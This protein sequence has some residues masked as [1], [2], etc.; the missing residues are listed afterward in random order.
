MAHW[1]RRDFFRGSFAAALAVACPGFL[2]PGGGVIAGPDAPPWPRTWS[3]VN[4]NPPEVFELA[5][6]I[7][8]GE[9]DGPSLPSEDAG[10]PEYDLIVVGGG[11]SG[12]A[13]ALRFR[14]EVRPGS[15]VLIL[16][17]HAE[18][19]GNAR[20]EAFDIGGRTLFATQAG[21]YVEEPWQ[22]ELRDF[23]RRLRVDLDRIRVP[24]DDDRALFDPVSHGCKPVWVPR[25]W[26]EGWAHA[27]V[28]AEDR[29]ALLAFVRTLTEAA[30]AFGDDDWVR[31]DGISFREWIE[32]ERGWPGAVTRFADLYCGDL[33]GARAGAVSAHAGIS[34]CSGMTG[35]ADIYAF[36]GGTSGFTRLAVKALLPDSLAGEPESDDFLAAAWNPEAL[37]RAGEPVRIRLRSTAVRVAHEG[38]PD[39]ARH[40]RVT[41]LRD[42]RLIHARGS[43]VILA[44]GGIMT[45]RIVR[46]LPEARRADFAR[47]R[48]GAYLVA[49]VGIRSSA[50]LDGAGL[51]YQGCL[52]DGFAGTIGVA[53]WVTSGAN[54]ARDPDRPNVLTLFCPLADPAVPVEEQGG[55]GRERLLSTPFVE[56][57]RLVLADLERALGPWGFSADRDVV[58]V[59]LNRWG[60]AMI[61]ACPGFAFERGTDGRALP[62]PC[63]RAAAPFGRLAFAHTDVS[64][65]P[66]LEAAVQEGR[67]AAREAGRRFR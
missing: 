51:G 65:L 66:Y 36:P 19:G 24:K 26:Q 32:K 18:P 20:R 58:A 62:G 38:D 6:R 14:D 40:V 16:E 52:F 27:P 41:Y 22:K 61:T 1:T 8:A 50:A 48:Y 37:D 30:G 63:R 15:R 21:A 31:L 5:H 59:S 12:L 34:F 47:F 2:G 35:E 55:R 39:S 45:R 49:N 10:D 60:H 43:A 17:N 4:G 46:D 23:Y 53:D 56:F 13:A 57:E 28:P 25:I 3:P 33:L 67:R 54:G 9:F 7:R 11:M 29:R 64:G 44:G 42:G